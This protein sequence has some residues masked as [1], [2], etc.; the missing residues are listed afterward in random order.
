[1]PATLEQ[2]HE[3][4]ASSRYEGAALLRAFTDL[5][6]GK[7]A[8]EFLERFDAETLL[9]IA[10]SGLEFSGRKPDEARV[11]V[12]NPSYQADGW[13]APYTVLEVNLKD[14]PS[15]WTRCAPS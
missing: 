2:L 3:R 4:I 1:M 15:S 12:Y 8:E 7:A 13:E 6:F 14:A 9:A 10:V 11:R 5:L